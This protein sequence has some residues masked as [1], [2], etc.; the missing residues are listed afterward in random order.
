MPR[1]KLSELTRQ[2][3][4]HPRGLALWRLGNEQE[5]ER[6]TLRAFRAGREGGGLGPRGPP[7]QGPEY[8]GR[9]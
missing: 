5:I 8:C 6:I 4:Q 3:R 7:A 2:C 9:G 1:P